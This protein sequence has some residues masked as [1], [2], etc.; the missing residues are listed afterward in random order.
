MVFTGVDTLK[1]AATKWLVE[2]SWGD[3]KGK[4]GYWGMS[5]EWFDEYVFCV[6]VNKKYVPQQVLDMFKTT[7]TVL[8]PWDPMYSF[9]R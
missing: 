2:N 1:G 5:D 9:M 7:P 8:P 6:V 4:K 3:S